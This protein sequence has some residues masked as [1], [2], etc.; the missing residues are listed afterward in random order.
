MKLLEK[1]NKIS[2][3]FGALN[4]GGRNTMQSYDYVKA[5]D[6]MKKFREFEVKYKIKVI[7]SVDPSTVQTTPTPSGKSLLTTILVRYDIRDL[8]SDEV[9]TVTLPSQGSD[10]NDKGV[11]KALTGAYK[12]F[13]LQ[14]FSYSS[15]DPEKED[16]S[17]PAITS[18]PESRFKAPAFT[19]KAKDFKNSEDT[20]TTAS[21]LIEKPKFKAAGLFKKA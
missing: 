17:E 10:S 19:P 16:S 12:Y 13:L 18:I 14:T 15:D 3:E 9:L 4:K 20:A 7:V 11:F 6:A 5:E 2:E 8:E 1:L 21:T